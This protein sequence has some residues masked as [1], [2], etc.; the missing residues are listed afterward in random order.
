MFWVFLPFSNV[1][2]GLN[3]HLRR[4][5]TNKVFPAHFYHKFLTALIIGYGNS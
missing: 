4:L 5:R 2:R 1:K 3:V